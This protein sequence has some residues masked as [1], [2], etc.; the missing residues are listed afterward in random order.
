MN[1]VLSEIKSIP[2]IIGGFFFDSIQGVKASNLS[3]I[4]K[5]DNLNKIGKV[6][7]K[8][9]TMSESGLKDISDLFLCYEESTI[10]IRR[11][12]NT[13]SLVIICDPSFNQNLLTMSMNML[14]EELKEI[15][16]KF[17][18][19]NEN[20][21][22]ISAG[23]GSRIEKISEEEIINNSPVSDQLQRMQTALFKILG[24]MAKIIFKEAV[25]DWSQ[26]QDPSETSI[27][28]LLE[29]L[30]KEINDPEKAK[31]YLE[32]VPQNKKGDRENL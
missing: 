32:M 2:G 6:L 28:A 26:M 10:I 8:M 12:G 15:S 23:V 24:P 19:A 16:L 18:Q 21:E 5:E 25:R 27:P 17:D 14:A 4:F 9:Y 11:I 3:P 13:S 30:I 7:Y 20:K 29:I 22:Q 31:K 1:N